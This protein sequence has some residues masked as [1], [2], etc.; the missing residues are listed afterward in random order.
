ML[1]FLAPVH[2]PGSA[3]EQRRGSEHPRA[4]GKFSP[5]HITACVAE[6][7]KLFHKALIGNR[8]SE[9]CQSVGEQCGLLN[10]QSLFGVYGAVGF[11]KGSGRLALHPDIPGENHQKYQ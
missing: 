1:H 9:G 10:R 4:Y 6:V 8:G 2:E 5:V 7:R 3:H 11:G